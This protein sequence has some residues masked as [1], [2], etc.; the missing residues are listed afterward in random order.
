M[1]K[2]KLEVIS[3]DAERLVNLMKKIN[4]CCWVHKS[5]VQ[6]LF[7]VIQKIDKGNTYYLD[8][9]KNVLDD[10]FMEIEIIKYDVKYHKLSLIASPNW[11]STFEPFV[12]VSYFWDF[13]DNCRKIIQPR[14]NNPQIYHQRYLFV[15]HDYDGFDVEADFQRRKHYEQFLTKEDVKKIGNYDY[16]KQFCEKHGI[17]L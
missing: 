11:N 5:N 17:E 2:R 8:K 13:D 12:G 15:N 14:K 4:S 7:E 6:E 9:V 3:S 1:L 10:Y 16:W